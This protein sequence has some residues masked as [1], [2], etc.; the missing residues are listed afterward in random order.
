M[1][2]SPETPAVPALGGVVP[3]RVQAIDVVRGLV[4]VVMALDH[5]RDF[6]S[7]T[8]FRP[9]DLSQTS[10]LLFFTRWITHFC[11]PTFVFLS[12]VSI[13]LQQ[14]KLKSQSA[15]SRFLLKRGLWL[16]LMEV[17]VIS[18][19]LQWSYS[20]ILLQVIWVI[21]CGM[22]L[23]AALLWLPRLALMLLAAFIL[24]GHNAL[25]SV[26]PITAATTGWALLHNGPFLLSVGLLPPLL[27][28]YSV[29][30]WLGVMLA[31]YLLGPW[32]VRPMSERKKLLRMTG[33]GMLAVFF[34]LRFTNWYGDP[35]P[36]S[37]QPK[38]GLYTALSF[39]N[40]SKYPP[41]LLFVCLTLGVSLLL[42][43]RLEAVDNRLTRWLRTFGQVPFFYFLLHLLVI[44]AGACLWTHWAFGQAINLAFANPTAWPKNYEPSLLRAY[45]VWAVVVLAL[46]WPCSWYRRFKQRNSYWW[47]AYL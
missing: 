35:T 32:F 23:L 19:L 11:A 44:S 18:F 25:P 30:P 3:M 39:L 46:Y 4:M 43:S 41:S 29:G 9:K 34:S 14:Q 26:Q 33:A 10:E 6:W 40:V 36:W 1:Y 24:V 15:T 2:P 47:L 42:L 21:G 13:W 16:V 28:A 27:V 5:V 38:G 37:V 8:A 17:G 12:G 31:G 7:P 45:V 22:V 20:M